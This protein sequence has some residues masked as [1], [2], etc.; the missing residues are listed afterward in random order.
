MDIEIWKRNNVNYKEH[1][2]DCKLQTTSWS[3]I[4]RNSCNCG[5]Q[6]EFKR[7]FDEGLK[8]K[9][10]RTTRQIDNAI[11]EFFTEGETRIQ[12]HFVTEG[13]CPNSMALQLNRGLAMKFETRL[14]TEHNIN[15]RNHLEI[16]IKGEPF[17][18]LY[19][20]KKK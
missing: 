8:R 12:D 13:G 17:C 1:S 5:F 7:L 3:D 19:K 9:S 18:I 20:L 15:P 10:G 14:S 2:K 11:Q 6:V 16:E 4:N